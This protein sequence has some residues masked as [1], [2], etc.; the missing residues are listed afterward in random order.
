MTRNGRAAVVSASSTRTVQTP[1]TRVSAATSR[2]NRVRNSASPDSSG[3]STFTATGLP[4]PAAARYTTPIP[5]APSRA[6]SR[7]DPTCAGSSSRRG[8]RANQSPFRQASIV[9]HQHTGRDMLGRLYF[10]PRMAIQARAS[11]T[12]GPLPPRAGRP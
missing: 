10:L 1:L 3:R 8:V 9:A 6:V 4:F 12:R 7:Y 11:A 5:P 2:L